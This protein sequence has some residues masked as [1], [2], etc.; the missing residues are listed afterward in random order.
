MVPITVLFLV[1]VCNRGCRSGVSQRS[2][3]VIGCTQPHPLMPR[4]QSDDLRAWGSVMAAF[5]VW[6]W[7]AEPDAPAR[8]SG[9]LS[10][11]AAAP[12]AYSRRRSPESGP[13]ERDSRLCRG[14]FTRTRVFRFHKL[15]FTLLLSSPELLPCLPPFM[16]PPSS[17]AVCKRAAGAL[18]LID[19]RL[20]PDWRRD[21]SIRHCTS[22]M[23]VYFEGDSVL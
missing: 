16:K 19:N 2:A 22:K 8:A 15:C 5:Q 3:C 10:A 20:L 13:L 12:G 14:H 11:V 21:T 1:D 6:G 9:L 4:L 23:H 7:G 18:A 17:G